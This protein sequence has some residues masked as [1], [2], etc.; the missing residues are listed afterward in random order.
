M[1]ITQNS[2]VVTIM[3]DDAVTIGWSTLSYEVDEDDAF[4]TVC[5]EI[6][7]GEIARPV[8]VFYSTTDDSA[9]G[10]IMLIAIDYTLEI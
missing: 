5:A 7:Q 6:V 3:D 8:I 4:V 9:L 2:A 1:D 10:N